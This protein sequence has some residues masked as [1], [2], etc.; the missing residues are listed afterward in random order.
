[1]NINIKMIHFCKFCDFGSSH[2]WVVRRHETKKHENQQN[3][4]QLKTSY[5]QD[6]PQPQPAQEVQQ[7]PIHHRQI[8]PP[9]HTQINLQ[10]N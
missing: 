8:P 4:S 1:M 5:M 2:K 6:Y 9:L 10:Q 7:Q 3:E